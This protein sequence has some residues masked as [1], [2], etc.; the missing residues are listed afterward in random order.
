MRILITGGAGFVGS[1]TAELLVRD[2]HQVVVVD[3]FSSGNESNLSAVADSIELFRLDIRDTANLSSAC[4]DIDVIMHFAAVSSVEKSILEPIATH[5]INTAG[6]LSVME[7]A[8]INRVPR[9]IF[10]SSAAVYGD[11]PELPKTESSPVQPQ[12]PYAWHKLTGEFYGR[13]YRELH[14]IDFLALRYF[15]VFGP[16]QNPDSSYTGV[17]TI[18]INRC[19]QNEPLL[20]YGSGEQT[21]DFIHVSDVA[22][23][24]L[25]AAKASGTLPGIINVACNVETKIIDLAR[26]IKA[27]CHSES[28]IVHLE[29]RPGDIYRSYASNK[30]LTATFGFTPAISVENGL[31]GL[32]SS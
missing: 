19:L 18:F 2:G 31:R 10:S 25:L 26:L 8:R 17:L 21:R 30:L 12:S 28:D 14:G 29:E 9:V 7:A 11:N 16:R 3:D 15:N 32:I 5:D 20:I 6:C 13:N 1:H 23:V 24:N 22:A 4:L 27:A